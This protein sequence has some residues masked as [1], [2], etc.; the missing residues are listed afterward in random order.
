MKGKKHGA[1][2]APTKK[3]FGH[4]TQYAPWAKSNAGT[5]KGKGK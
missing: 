5:K 3:S 2:N 4:S 1:A